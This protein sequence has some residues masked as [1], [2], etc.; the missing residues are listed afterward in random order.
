VKHKNQRQH[1]LRFLANV[2]NVK[3]RC[4]RPAVRV[5][6]GSPACAVCIEIEERLERQSKSAGVKR[7]TPLGIEPY[8]CHLPHYQP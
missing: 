6:R 2:K 5:S 8:A 3:C 1:Q 7:R 4:S